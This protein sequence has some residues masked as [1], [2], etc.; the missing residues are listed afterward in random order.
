MKV[1]VRAQCVRKAC[2]KCPHN[3]LII[4]TKNPMRNVCAKCAHKV[5]VVSLQAIE[6]IKLFH[7]CK[8]PYIP[9]GDIYTH[10]LAGGGVF[11][12]TASAAIQ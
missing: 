1:K 7:V 4:L 12:G 5:R 9:Y 6:F 8:V 11:A 3:T 2:A 10:P